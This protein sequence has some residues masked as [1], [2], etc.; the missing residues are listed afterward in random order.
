MT[1]AAVNINIARPVGIKSLA[2]QYIS[3]TRYLNS[4]L[5]AFGH[6]ASGISAS[7]VPGRSR[8][9]HEIFMKIEGPTE[10]TVRE[11]GIYHGLD[12]VSKNTFLAQAFLEKG[13]TGLKLNTAFTPEDLISLS[14]T[15]QPAFA[16]RAA[17]ITEKET[18][19]QLLE[20][21]KDKNL[22]SQ[23]RTYG[24]VGIFSC[25]S[26]FLYR[27]ATLVFAE[28]SS[29]FA[30][31]ALMTVGIAFDALLISKNQQHLISGQKYLPPTPAD[32]TK[33]RVAGEN[34]PKA[35]ILVPALNEPLE[36]MRKTLLAAG[37]QD[38]ANKEVVLLLDDAPSSNGIPQIHEMVAEVNRQLTAEGQPTCVKVFE[39][40]KYQNVSNQGRNKADNLNAFLVYAN[41]K[42]LVERQNRLG[43]MV[44]LTAEEYQ[45]ESDTHSFV[46]EMAFQPAQYLT[47]IDADY[48]LI[49]SFLTETVAVLEEQPKTAMVQTPQNLI[50]E[51]ASE[52]ER[53]SAL[54]INSNWRYARRGNARD[55]SIFW[56]G[57]NCT[58]RLGALES[59]KQT[60]ADKIEYVPTKNIT[61]DLYS[62]LLLLKK[63]WDISFLP[64]PMAEGLPI[65]NLADHLTTFWR[66]VEGTTEATIEQIVPHMIK[67]PSYAFSKQGS[68]FLAHA[69][70]GF[71]GYP[72]VF[73][74]L[75][76]IMAALG[77]KFAPI[78]TYSFMTLMTLSLAV[79]S[80]SA[81]LMMKNLGAKPFDS[82]KCSLLFIMHYPAYIHAT[83]TAIYNAITGSRAQFLRTPKDGARSMVPLKY[84]APLLGLP[85][86]NLLSFGFCLNNYLNGDDGQIH[87]AV[88]SLFNS[89]V[90][91]YGLFY[92]NGAKN[93]W[94]DIKTGVARLF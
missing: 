88:W 92:F 54:G 12:P 69:L 42:S 39:R 7:Y 46:R 48:K 21:V 49:P 66:Y 60:L 89:S 4:T 8:S 94:K 40:K 32:T 33:T 43:E 85:A 14:K 75:S 6:L 91:T 51:G 81:W 45:A 67:N 71:M 83:G 55:G 38:Y 16:N 13:F 11:D 2:Y 41:G 17:G 62:T 50:P 36:V 57:T 53:I 87:P 22:M 28:G 1:Q 72:T 84:L 61:E 20:I 37:R 9:C 29:G 15:G 31:S 68:E 52:I 76:P 30:F 79:N 18:A 63:G 90:L 44:L 59:I 10:L 77:V 27:A 56:G 25:V 78:E 64:R 34:G 82:F 58:L 70:Q 93:T 80:R 23:L 65:S 74:G 73:F 24:F 3:R 35:T 19:K 47:I 5:D 26:Y 86:L